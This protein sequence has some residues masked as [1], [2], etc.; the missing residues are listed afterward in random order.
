MNPYLYCWFAAMLLVILTP[1]AL[2]FGVDWWRVVAVELVEVIMLI[3]VGWLK[4]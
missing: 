3:F 4:R 1:M 2:L